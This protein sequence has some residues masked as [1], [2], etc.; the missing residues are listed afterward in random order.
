MSANDAKA[1]ST[2]SLQHKLHQNNDADDLNA[3]EHPDAMLEHPSYEELQNKLTEAEEKAT[4]SWERLLRLQADMDNMQRRAERDVANAH[5][6]ALEKFVL[7]LLPI[8][9]GL[10]RALAA[11]ANEQSGPDSLLDGVHLTLKMLY[12][13]FEKFGIQ[14]V[15]PQS[16]PFNPEQHQAVS[17]QADPNT[18][19]GTVLAV[20]QKGYLLNNRLIRPALVVVAK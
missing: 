16:Q 6:Y 13:T 15:D 12:T 14:Q 9:D 5:K 11:H 1:G 19:S 2:A 8:V 10:E 7:E 17:T 4:Q 3:E 18:Q 20:L